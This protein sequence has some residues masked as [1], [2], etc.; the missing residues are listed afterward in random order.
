MWKKYHRV[1]FSEAQSAE[2]RYRKGDWLKSIGR[3]PG[4]PS[5]CILH[6]W[7]PALESPAEAIRAQSKSLI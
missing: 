2:L 6:I 5:S 1:G 7:A 4:K 3:V